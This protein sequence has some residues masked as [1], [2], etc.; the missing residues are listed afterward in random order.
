[1]NETLYEIAYKFALKNAVEHNG[2]CQKD[3][4]RKMCVGYLKEKGYKIDK[5][6]LDKLEKVL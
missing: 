2:K 6:L 4:V 5:E 3:A 1:M